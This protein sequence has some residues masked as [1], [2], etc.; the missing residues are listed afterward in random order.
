MSNV[1]TLE[2]RTLDDEELMGVVGG[3]DSSCQPQRCF[4]RCGGGIDINVDIDVHICL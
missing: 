1:E 4:S 2:L 3:C